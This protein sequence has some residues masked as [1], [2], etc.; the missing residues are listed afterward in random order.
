[1]FSLLI[2]LCSQLLLNWLEREPTRVAARARRASKGGRTVLF[3]NKSR[4]DVGD[5][6][7]DGVG[8][9]VGYSKAIHQHFPGSS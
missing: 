5:G 3:A 9:A 4:S 8:I 6:K 7:E 2:F 1:M